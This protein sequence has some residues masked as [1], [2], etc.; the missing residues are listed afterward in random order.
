MLERFG[1]ILKV[2][3]CPTTFYPML[4]KILL[5]TG[6]LSLTIASVACLGAN[7]T[8]VPKPKAYPTLRPIVWAIPTAT[9]V[10][11][12]PPAT[13]T[14]TP[15]PTKVPK[16][17][18]VDATQQTP[19][20]VP[21]PTPAPTPMS[22]PTTAP[23]PTPIAVPTPVPALTRET[24]IWWASHG[25]SLSRQNL[26]GVDLS[27]HAWG[28][29]NF[30]YANLS[31]ADFTGAILRLANLRHADLTGADLTGADLSGA[32]LTGADTTGATFRDLS[33]LNWIDREVVLTGELPRIPNWFFPPLT[34]E[35]IVT[36]AEKGDRVAQGQ[37]F[38][39]GGKDWC[40]L[41]DTQRLMLMDYVVWQGQTIS[42]WVDSQ[43]LTSV[44]DRCPP[45]AIY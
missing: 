7:E 40:G 21:T 3:L 17:E 20:P 35:P 44:M 9:Y 41:K 26:E 14:P 5:I 4:R 16:S 39:V 33:D 6:I 27:N 25:L 34:E 19:N 23:R 29:V 43:R 15:W 12:Y 36:N 32:D 8:T 13:P 42:D 31:G 10:P 1:P 2:P 28:G 11:T 37:E 24:A 18:I 38:W 22:I 30:S 45:A